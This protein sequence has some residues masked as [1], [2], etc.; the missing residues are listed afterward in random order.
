V[1][2]AADER[3]AIIEGKILFFPSRDRFLFRNILFKIKNI[4]V[5]LQEGRMSDSLNQLHKPRQAETSDRYLAF[6]LS[7]EQYAIPLL[8]V[9]EVIGMIPTTSIPQMPAYFK[10]ILNLRGVIIS[11]VDLRS[12]LQLPKVDPGPETSIIILDLSPLCIGVIVDSVNS[13]LALTGEELSPPPDIQSN[14]E[15]YVTGVAKKDNRLTLLLD[16]GSL[17]SVEDI[18]ALKVQAEAAA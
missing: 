13:V 16:I 14:D 18:K 10:G 5:D 1:L 3:A 7:Q 9:K 6:S 11:V 15:A 8:Q 17:L 4:F 2:S 12:K